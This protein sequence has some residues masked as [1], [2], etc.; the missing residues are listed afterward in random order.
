MEFNLFTACGLAG[1]SCFI[2]SYFATLQGWLAPEG[3]RL[4]A[5]NLLGAAMVLISLTVAWNLPS[6]MLECFWGALSLYGVI[7]AIGRGSGL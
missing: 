7:R 2:F 6:V 1:A 4:P 3:W 5:L